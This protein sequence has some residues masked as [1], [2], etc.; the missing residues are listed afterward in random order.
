MNIPTKPDD[1]DCCGSGCTPCIFDIYEEQLKKYKSNKTEPE[2]NDKSNCLSL[3]S[4][5]IFK[6]I[7]I[8]PESR[9]AFLYTFKLKPDSDEKKELLYSPGQHFLLR[10]EQSENRYFT[11]AYTPIP[12]ENSNQTPDFFTVLV[13]LYEDGLMSNY[14]RKLSLNTETYW[15]GPYGTYT[16]NYKLNNVLMICQGTG[17][18]PLFSIINYYV[19][20][21]TSE[22]FIKLFYC[23]RCDESIHLRNEIH[24]LSSYWNFTYEVFLSRNNYF[25]EKK[26]NE[27][28][29]CRRLDEHDLTQYFDVKKSGDYQILI[30]GTEAFNRNFVDLIINKGVSEELIHVF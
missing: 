3:T 26:Y 30:C 13:K 29:H 1:S 17:I 12:H 20:N 28:I 27:T 24:R 7:K 16:I 5:T 9:D 25:I 15:R 22:T 18:A 19:N 6:I 10:G 23:C 11:R 8:E 14:L 4:Y 21:E 2:T